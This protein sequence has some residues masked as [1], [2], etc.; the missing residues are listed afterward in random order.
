MIQATF[1]KSGDFFQSVTISGHAEYA[2]FGQDIVCAAVTSALQ[3]TAN[4]ITQV[5]GVDAA[6]LVEE[7]KISV[8]LPDKAPVGASH[9]LS[10]LHLH[11]K[12]LQQDYSDHITITLVEV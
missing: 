8:T 12:V 6:V 3:L 1:E 2:D 9:F 7:N 10:A 5:V 11:L 4:G